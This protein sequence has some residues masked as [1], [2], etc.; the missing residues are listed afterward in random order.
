ME[1]IGTYLIITKNYKVYQT[2]HITQGIKLSFEEDILRI[3]WH[4]GENY[5]EVESIEGNVMNFTPITEYD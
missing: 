2:N 1:T 4:N 5:F 3:V